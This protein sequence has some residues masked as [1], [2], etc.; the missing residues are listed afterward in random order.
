MA[1]A[2]GGFSGSRGNGTGSRDGRKRGEWR[3]E[4]EAAAVVFKEAEGAA[5]W[6][7]FLVWLAGKGIG[8]IKQ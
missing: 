8:S 3:A 4:V 7:Y 5:V 2:R 1:A 6:Y